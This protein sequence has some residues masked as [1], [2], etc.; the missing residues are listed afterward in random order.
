M[1]NPCRQRPIPLLQSLNSMPLILLRATLQSRIVRTKIEAKRTA[2]KAVKK[3]GKVLQTIARFAGFGFSALL[4]LL[5][6][7]DFSTIWDTVVN[8]YF[9]IKYFDWNATD[10]AIQSQIDSNNK[11]IVTAA[12]SALGTTLGWSVMRLANLWIGRFGGKSK[13]AAARSIKVPVL[14]A[15]VG[16]AL[17]EEGNE[18]IRA[19]VYQFLTTARQ[20]MISNT[21]LSAVLTARRNEWFGMSSVTTAMADGSIATKIEEKIEKLPEFWRQPAEEFIESFEEAIIDAGYVVS[22]QIDDHIAAV[23]A[24]QSEQPVRTIEVEFKDSDEKLSF[25]GPQELVKQAVVNA[26]ATREVLADRD[27]GQVLGYPITEQE[28]NPKL[29]LRQLKITYSSRSKAPWWVEPKPR[30]SNYQT[31]NRDTDKKETQK[32]ARRA[33]ITIPDVKPGLTWQEIKNAAGT[34]R[35]GNFLVSM[36]LESGRD[37]QIWAA[38]P[39]EGRET[40]LR[41]AKLSQ[42]DPIEGTLRAEEVLDLNPERKK[43]IE[44]MHPVFFVLLW[45]KQSVE[46]GGKISWDGKTYNETIQKIDLWPA[47]APEDYKPAR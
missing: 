1:P 32:R 33:D 20:A 19:G 44:K 12:A 35:R 5:P 14:S 17:A 16:L 21:L 45:R 6:P 24:A 38:T 11:A 10:Q 9:T 4:K 29:Q 2:L 41:L 22:F 30:S 7:L 23:K 34:Y 25:S 26:L 3:G 15:R 39:Q 42:F 46:P 18:E 47:E 31:G 37:M 27:V 8:A 43:P 40:L 28:W 36:M 13:A